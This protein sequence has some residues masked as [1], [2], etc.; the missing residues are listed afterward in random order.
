[1]VVAWPSLQARRLIAAFLSP[2]AAIASAQGA[3]EAFW[4]P[5][6]CSQLQLFG[7]RRRVTPS[8]ATVGWPVVTPLT[9][10]VTPSALAVDG[11]LSTRY[12]SNKDQARAA[13]SG[14][15]WAGK[16]SFHEVVMATPN[17]P[18]DYARRFNVAV[19]SDGSTWSAVAPVRAP[20]LRR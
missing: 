3:K 5:A 1:M 12:S 16:Q 2:S 6:W 14:W 8:I 17:S 15:T 19:S 20:A 10:R 4:L 11:D 18:N 9:R 13:C 7:Q